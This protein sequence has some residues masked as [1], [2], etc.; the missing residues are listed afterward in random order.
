ML[1]PR[2]GRHHRLRASVARGLGR[3]PGRHLRN[4]A[5]R[6]RRTE[7]G[8]CER[9]APTV[10]VRNRGGIDLGRTTRLVPASEPPDFPR[11]VGHQSTRGSSWQP[12]PARPPSTP[13]GAPPRPSPESTGLTLLASVRAGW[14]RRNGPGA[15]SRPGPTGASVGASVG[16]LGVL[17]TRNW[18]TQGLLTS[19]EA[20]RSAAKPMPLM[21]RAAGPIES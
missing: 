8:R 13:A 4:A 1:R 15:A 11:A 3:R 2:R 20:M 21:L 19:R 14:R 12:R 17:E 5:V 6:S 10:P 7:P 18:A 16:A 9:A